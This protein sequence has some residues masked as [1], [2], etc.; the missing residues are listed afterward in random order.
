M[1]DRSFS[2]SSYADVKTE[3]SIGSRQKLVLLPHLRLVEA[4]FIWF[5]I[6]VAATPPACL[7]GR[8]GQRNPE[9]VSVW[10]GVVGL[11]L[12]G[13]EINPPVDVVR[14]GFAFVDNLDFENTD[15][16]SYLLGLKVTRLPSWGRIAACSWART[17]VF[18]AICTDLRALSHASIAKKVPKA[19]PSPI[20][21][22]LSTET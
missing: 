3:G 18:S 8:K 22:D 11:Q 16:R 20:I 5:L 10:R 1:V 19:P 4:C 13:F 6:S 15:V 12:I 14:C 9:L 2:L 21:T 17:N 7:Y